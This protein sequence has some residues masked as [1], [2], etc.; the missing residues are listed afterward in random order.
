MPLNIQNNMTTLI[1]KKFD[2][3]TIS[4]SEEEGA[5][6]YLCP[7]GSKV[8]SVT[9]LLSRTQK[10]EKLLA[11]QEWRDKVG[12]LVAAEITKAAC[13]RGSRMHKNL[14][15][16][17]ESGAL[18]QKGS[19]P[20]NHLGLQ[21]AQTIIDNGLSH[22][23]EFWGSEVNLYYPELYAGTTDCVGIHKGEQAIIDFKQSNRPKTLE[24]VEDYFCQVILYALAHNHLFDTDIK[25]GVIM[26]C[27]KP[28]E[29][30]P[31]K[32]ATPEYQ[33]FIISGSLWDEYEAQVFSRI[34]QYYSKKINHATVQCDALLV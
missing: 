15:I 13:Q 23:D 26:I 20:Y 32:W 33:E 12:H 24:H 9:T 6:L 19:N 14:E 17:L 1:T 7:D 11:L 34:E 4:R 28:N 16:Y 3:A 8:P 5:R 22:V 31:G 30:S 29:I 21:M 25:K 27:V 2:Y 18:P 10:K